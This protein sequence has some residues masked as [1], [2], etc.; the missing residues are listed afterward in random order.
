MGFLGVLGLGLIDARALGDIFTAIE[1]GDDCARLIQCLGCRLH[2]V[3]PHIG[4]Q[5]DGLAADVDS[6]IELLC[7]LHGALRRKAELARSFLL[8]S[9]GGEGRGRR[10]PGGLLLDSRNLE[11][12]GL[13]GG[14]C[15]LG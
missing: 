2:A 12:R 10:A 3:G 8:Q 15:S 7:R 1:P 9:R 6:L 11:G 13:D 14:L 4:D 5:A